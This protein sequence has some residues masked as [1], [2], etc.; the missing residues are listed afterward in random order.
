MRRRSDL[1]TRP[2]SVGEEQLW[3]LAGTGAQAVVRLV[4]VAK[5]VDQADGLGL[6][7]RTRSRVDQLAYPIKWQTTCV[8]D[9]LHGAAEDR[10]GQPLE[11]LAVR[12]TVLSPQQ[13]VGGVLVLMSLLELRLNP[14]PVQGAAYERRLDAD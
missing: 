10:L 13:R 4:A 8:G 3:L 12:R 7:C 1:S 11:S 9:G 14:K 6:R 5:P 2:P